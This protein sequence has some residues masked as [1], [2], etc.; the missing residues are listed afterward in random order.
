MSTHAALP[1][2]HMTPISGHPRLHSAFWDA[3]AYTEPALPE[4]TP[5]LP[6]QAAPSNAVVEQLANIEARLTNIEARLDALAAA[7][8]V[9][10]QRL[11]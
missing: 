1:D 8:G 7:L 10:V 4:P 9:L 2:Y 6:L 5:E 11:V 3:H